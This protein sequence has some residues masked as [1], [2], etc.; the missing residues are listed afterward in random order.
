VTHP[1]RLLVVS[2]PA[3]LPVNQLVYAELAER[4]WQVD[5]IV[6]DRWGHEYGEI[7]PTPL[8][9]LAGGYHPLPVVLSGR[10]QRHVYRIRLGRVLRQ[11][12]PDVL[13]LEQEPFSVS[14]LQWGLAAERAGIPFGVQADENLDRRLPAPVRAW[15]S[16]VLGHA[17]FVAARSDRAAELVRQWGATGDVRLIP[18]HVP[19]WPVT[20]RSASKS[21]RVG[22]AG[23][24]VEEK[25]LDVLVGAVRR[26]GTGTEL[27]VAGAGPLREWLEAEDLGGAR[28]ELRSGLDHSAMSD[29]YA[30]MDVLVLP[31]RTTKTWAEQFG[32]V[33]IEA[34]WCGVPVVG[35]DS[36]E[37]P[38]VIETTG[39]GCV[40]PEGDADALASALAELRDDPVRRRDL[41]ARGRRVVEAT[42]SVPAVTGALDG[43]L[44]EAAGDRRPRV[45]LVAHGVHD[46]GGMERA[47]AELI[48]HA[49]DEF[50]F[51]V[52]AAELEPAL[53]SLVERWV[54][55]RVPMRPIPLKFVTFFAR[56]GL[57]VR[58]L[59]V[60]LVHTIG[61]I[62]PNR[63]DVA[64][65]HFC[66]A[67][68]RASAG[69]L[70]P[71]GAPWSRRLNTGIARALALTAERWCY[72]RAR[73]RA[74]AAVS[75]GVAD[76]LRFLYQGLPVTVTPN[77]IDLDRFRP[78]PA[79]RDRTRAQRGV[80]AGQTVALFVG[81]DWDRKGLGLAIDAV[82][83]SRAHGR[84]V[85]L[86]VVG[87][88]DEARFQARADALG[89]GNAV[90]FF[91]RRTD[92]E[93]FYRAAD[94][95]VL[96]SEY[97]TFSIVCFEAAACGL[98]V[99][100]PP[101]HGVSDLIG[102]GEAGTVVERDADS[103]AA[104][105]VTLADPATRAPLGEEARRRAER[106]TW[107]RSATSVLDLY[108]SLLPQGG[109]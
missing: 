69:H 23:R 84:D 21:F 105:L 51:T 80:S 59:D 99:V 34:L 63:V 86:W 104:A 57:A 65:V 19:E 42:F 97:E 9:A 26:L 29:A 55:I 103:V 77:G 18:H 60:D 20:E 70:A 5:L 52:V 71:V 90:V 33:L 76:E 38:W 82:A 89:A 79:E 54:R 74:F 88:G 40:V 68:H 93:R 7:T 53:R 81:G 94:V 30:S 37:I 58:G 85:L 8:P 96:P 47:C 35:S 62:V 102:D 13:F 27:V 73:L 75:G 14:A 17:A 100:A 28:L 64:G 31:S 101:L 49:H 45:A 92:T 16:W 50:A 48:R 109:T 36:G 61:A 41:A 44:R 4:G 72:R 11:L 22:Y 46:N 6:P 78:D 32:R 1:L 87:P 12:R 95:F 106:Y 66:H 83:K 91:G 24:L 25:G 67:G 56:A 39:G 43:V 2:H 98:P 15:R 107:E 108:R 3:V 10:E